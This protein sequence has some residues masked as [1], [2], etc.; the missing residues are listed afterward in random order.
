MFSSFQRRSWPHQIESCSHNIC[1]ATRS[2]AKTSEKLTCD[3]NARKSRKHHTK[4]EG[5]EGVYLQKKK[6]QA[7]RPKLVGSV[8]Q[9][10]FPLPTWQKYLSGLFA[11][12]RFLCQVHELLQTLKFKT[13]SSWRLFATLIPPTCKLFFNSAGTFSLTKLGSISLTEI[14]LK[15]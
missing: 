2:S 9:F 7:V 12:L 11:R 13:S 15:S 6:K 3:S 1:I 5:Q 4:V 10:H 14:V 8:Q